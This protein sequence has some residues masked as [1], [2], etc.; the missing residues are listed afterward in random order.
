MRCRLAARVV[1]ATLSCGGT[2]AA[3]TLTHPDKPW[4]TLRLPHF[5]VD[6]PRAMR[7]WALDM[8][9]RL[10]RER[11]AVIALVGYDPPR[12]VTIIVDDPYHES[13]GFALP[14]LGA[15]VIYVWPMPP[16]PGDELGHFRA[17]DEVVVVHEFAHIAHLTRPSRN[18]WQRFIWGILP[19]NI[20]P[21]A[22]RS[23]RWLLEGYATHIEGIVTGSGRP[24]SAARAAVLRAFALAGQLPSYAEVSNAPG[25]EGSAMA[26]LAGSAFLEWLIAQRGEGSLRNLWRRMTARTDR[27]F[28]AAFAGVFPGTPS[29]L[30]G[31]FTAELTGS[32]LAAAHAV[33]NAGLDSGVTVQRLAWYTGA[34]AA[35]P[36]GKLLAIPIRSAV[37]PTRVVVWRTAADPI[38]SAAL[39]RARRRAFERDS[40]DV[41]A[42]PYAPPPK[43][44]VATLLADA[45]RAYEA[46]RFLA[47][48]RQVLV[49]RDEPLPDGTFRPDLFLW[50]LATG[51]VRRVTHRAGIATADPTPDGRSA[52]GV[53]CSG[54]VCDLVIVSL[55]DG[56]IRTLAPGSPT[57]QFDRPRVAPDGQSV[58]VSIHA[59]GADDSTRA[60]WRLALLRLP[61]D[62]SGIRYIGPAD[63]ASRYDPAW[64]PDGRAIV[65]VSEAGGLQHLERI[66]LSTGITRPLALTTGA[67]LAPEPVGADSAIYFLTD[68]VQGRTLSR[69][70]L[71]AGAASHSMPIIPDTLAPAVVPASAAASLDS[72]PPSGPLSS[73]HAYGAGARG[74]RVLPG[75]GLA[76]DGRYGSLMVGSTDP[77]GR[78]GW[79]LQGVLGD[80][81]TWRGG[82]F[83]TTWRDL[84][85]LLPGSPSIDFAVAAVDQWPSRQSAGDFAAIAFPP[86]ALDADE[87]SVL[88]AIGTTERRPWGRDAYRVGGSLGSLVIAGGPTRGRSLAF[89]EYGAEAMYGSDQL[90]ASFTGSVN[91]AV[92]HT[93]GDGWQ[94]IRGDAALAGGIGDLGLRASVTYGITSDAPPFERFVAGG[95]APPLTDSATLAE[96]VAIPALPLGIVGGQSLLDYRLATDGSGPSWY[97]ESVS[98]GT[99]FRVWQRLVGVEQHVVVPSV[100]FARMP[101]VDVTGGMGY[102]LT[103]PFRDKLRGYLSVSYAP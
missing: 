9:R 14:F 57:R 89:A 50:T 60:Y 53:R 98:A 97:Y 65:A 4:E 35:S 69:I 28:D 27:D 95:G 45:G 82:A 47:D 30:Y 25:Y 41:P 78:L 46:P 63:G 13:N 29:E 66:E 103:A 38:D 84:G 73:P 20:G 6:Y 101:T 7:P 62:S 59:S 80:P 39:T 87:R 81:G 91:G 16:D 70:A 64:L 18:P 92:G 51:H 102:S 32:A 83:A 34:P 21:I 49:S 24:S 77:I 8:A 75:L 79:T 100:P 10:E 88:I 99:D 58:V 36:D 37:R 72:L 86:G 94:R 17:W 33:A 96:R 44:P 22:R 23:P 76:T 12:R 61:P 85:G 54:G 93:E 42:I 90:Y 31:H 68:G 40:E 5:T 71:S 2:A 1:A 43:H 11:L 48:G 55:T 56:G 19:E 67:V 3:Q 26:Y 15:P 74:Y 52:V